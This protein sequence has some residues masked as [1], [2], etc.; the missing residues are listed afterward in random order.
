MTVFVAR[1]RILVHKALKPDYQLLAER[2]LAGA[3]IEG[4]TM[5]TG[6][7]ADRIAIRELLDSYSD[8]DK[9]W[10]AATAGRLTWGKFNDDLKAAATRRR[11][12]LAN[13]L[14]SP[15]PTDPQGPSSYPASGSKLSTKIIR[16]DFTA[17]SI[18]FR[19]K[20]ERSLSRVICKLC[21]LSVFA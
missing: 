16:C 15:V 2:N 17:A 5:F 4:E 9:V 7:D 12:T 13:A 14:A 3:G 6:P 18:C 20:R 21:V 11:A 19:T 10:T 8:D 1:V